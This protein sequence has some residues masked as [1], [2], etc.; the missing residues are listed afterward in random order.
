MSDRTSISLLLLLLAAAVAPAQQ[1]PSLFQQAMQRAVAAAQQRALRDVDVYVDHSKWE[2]AWEVKTD[3]VVVRTNRSYGDGMKLAMGQEQM[4]QHMARTLGIDSLP[5]QPMHVYV[6]PDTAAY[7]AF[8]GQHGAEHSSFYGSFY[9]N[10]PPE[11]A[12]AVAWVDNATLLNM[13]IT[14]SAVHW[15]LEQV[16][17]GARPVWVEEGLA[18][19]FAAFWDYNWVLSEFERL[20]KEEALLP[21]RK[22]L[23]DGLPAYTQET[24]A[25]FTQ[26]AMLFYYLLRYREDTRTTQADETPQQAPFRDWL[27]ALRSG[28]PPPEAMQKMFDQP[29]QL[30]RDL[31]AFTFPR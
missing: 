29:A 3:H 13:Q 8:G 12:V 9:A 7:N 31:L 14:H 28:S 16:W 20:K 15:Y 22:L 10:Q 11:Q 18:S 21:L 24:H 25:R 26:L 19:Y 27:S 23:R 30:E 5:S 2:N 17:T 1:R 4:L 6:L